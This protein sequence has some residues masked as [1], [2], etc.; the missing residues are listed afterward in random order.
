LHCFCIL[1]KEKN[2]NLLNISDGTFYSNNTI[3]HKLDPRV[4]LISALLMSI[5]IA[6]SKNYNSLILSLLVA[7]FLVFLC[8]FK[9]AV[10][11]KRLLLINFF[12]LLVWLLVPFTTSGKAVFDV[13]GITATVEGFDIAMAITLKTNAIVMINMALLTSSSLIDLVHALH[14][15][16]FPDKAVYL[17]SFVV[18][19][20]DI[21]WNEYLR[22]RVAMKVRGFIP[23]T[24]IHTYKTY[25]YL[26][27]MVL[28]RSVERAERVYQAML[29]R[30][31]TGTFY[32]LDHF[33][34][35]KSDLSILSVF[36]L[37]SCLIVLAAFY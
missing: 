37:L 30:G 26:I 35:R 29:C 3:I 10:V 12:T 27:A 8:K 13:F 9:P 4:K 33:H 32:T 7:V 22:L 19:Y 17:F 24:N 25:A 16:K 21:T 14:H 20:L 34:L 23:K 18:R 15:L 1:P 28:V 36:V 31:F 2:N 5:V 6:L 11:L